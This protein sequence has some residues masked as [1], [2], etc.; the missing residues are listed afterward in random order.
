MEANP[1]VASVEPKQP[2]KKVVGE[3]RATSVVS[4]RNRYSFRDRFSRMEKLFGPEWLVF[5][6]GQL[7]AVPD[8]K[9]TP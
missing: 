4:C 3:V 1:V 6:R 5:H 9:R 7:G 8:M 2:V